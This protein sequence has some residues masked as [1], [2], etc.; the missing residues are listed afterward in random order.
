MNRNLHPIVGDILIQIPFGGGE[1]RVLVTEVDA[2]IKN[3]KP[4]FSGTLV[5]VPVVDDGFPRISGVW[6][7]DD[8]IVAII[9]PME[10]RSGVSV[11]S[12][13]HA[14]V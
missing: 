8:Q 2:E 11:P 1:R 12:R 14:G 4:G 7:Y 6:G 3:G 9:S 5:D 13:F 10:D